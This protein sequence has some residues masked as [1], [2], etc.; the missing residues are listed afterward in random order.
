MRPKKPARNTRE[1]KK[2]QFSHLRSSDETRRFLLWTLPPT[3]VL[4]I[5]NLS[6]IASSVPEICDFKNWLGFFVF[7]FLFFFLFSQTY[8]TRYKTRP[9]YPITLQFGTQK[10]GYKGTSLYQLLLEYDKQAELLAI[11]HEK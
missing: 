7:S 10:G 5:P 6:E 8:K 9:Q 1:R 11:I 4:H 3:S 2:T